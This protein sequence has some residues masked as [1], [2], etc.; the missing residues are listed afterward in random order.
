V[1]QHP[2]L[3]AR[4]AYA[5]RGGWV[6]ERSVSSITYSDKFGQVARNIITPEMLSL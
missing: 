4:D 3:A 2:T 6:A 1:I 5:S